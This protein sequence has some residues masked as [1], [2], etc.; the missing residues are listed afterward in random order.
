[1][2]AVG[3]RQCAD[4]GRAACCDGRLA[5][6]LQQPVHGRQSS[7]A[8]LQRRLPAGL[9][10]AGRGRQVIAVCKSADLLLMVLD[11]GKPH[12]HREI[13]TRELEAVSWAC[14]MGCVYISFVPVHSCCQLVGDPGVRAGGGDL[15]GRQ[16]RGIGLWQTPAACP[17]FWEVHLLVW[18]GCKVNL[19]CAHLLPGCLLMHAALTLFF[20]LRRWACG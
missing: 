18:D 5:G 16:L 12:Y 14:A 7:I 19:A 17:L 8:C 15:L 6:D 11:A 3:S 4:R 1:M 2:W 20:S 13:L 10:C 9:L